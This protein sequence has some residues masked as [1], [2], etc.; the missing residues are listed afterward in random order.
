MIFI[1]FPYIKAAF[2]LVTYVAKVLMA[3]N[4]VNLA[5]KGMGNNSSMENNIISLCGK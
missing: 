4:V 1:P 5:K 2:W 3:R